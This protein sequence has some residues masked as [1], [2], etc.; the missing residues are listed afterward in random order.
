M[1]SCRGFLALDDDWM[2]KAGLFPSTYLNIGAWGKGLA[3]VNGLYLGAYWPLR[4]PIN[5][6]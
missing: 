3:F 6:M 1:L 4:G 5:T 2:D